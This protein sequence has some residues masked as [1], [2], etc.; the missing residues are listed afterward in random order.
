M[1]HIFLINFELQEVFILITAL[2]TKE[3]PVAKNVCSCPKKACNKKTAGAELSQ[4]DLSYI[5]FDQASN[6]LLLIKI[7]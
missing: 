2:K 7:I 4:F 1:I 6:F 3:S 5:S